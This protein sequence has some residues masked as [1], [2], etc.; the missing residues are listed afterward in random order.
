MIQFV[1]QAEP[2]ISSSFE[3]L[4][5]VRTEQRVDAALNS[6]QKLELQDDGESAL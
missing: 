3:P 5:G 6:G 4:W 1:F 2:E